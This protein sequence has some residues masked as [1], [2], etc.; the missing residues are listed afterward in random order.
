VQ[1]GEPRALRELPG[2]RML[3]PAR[4][5]DQNLHARDAIRVGGGDEAL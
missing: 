1:L 2:E 5:H 3:A 4:P